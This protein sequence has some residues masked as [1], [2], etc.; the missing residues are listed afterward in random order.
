MSSPMKVAII[1]LMT[2]KKM[3]LI[4]LNSYR[5]SINLSESTPDNESA[6]R[7]PA[8]GYEE[9]ISTLAKRRNEEGAAKKLRNARK[10]V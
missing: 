10:Y 2:L 3:T 6:K 9:E 4:K 1:R 7:R 8:G 5:P